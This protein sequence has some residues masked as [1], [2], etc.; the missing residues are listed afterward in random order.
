MF[1]QRNGKIFHVLE[2]EELILLKWPYYPEQAID[3]MGLLSNYP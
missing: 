3:L 2:L 1:I